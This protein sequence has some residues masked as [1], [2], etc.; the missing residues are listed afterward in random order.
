MHFIV[1][2]CILLLKML[3]ELCGIENHIKHVDG[4]GGLTIQSDPKYKIIN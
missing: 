4:V 2:N 3:I 1:Q